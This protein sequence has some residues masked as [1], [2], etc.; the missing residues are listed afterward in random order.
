[1]ASHWVHLTLHDVLP[2]RSVCEREF[3]GE[4]EADDEPLGTLRGVVF[5]L[6]LEVALAGFGFAGWGLWRLIR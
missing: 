1:M 2:R 3:A 6:A 4:R 5:A